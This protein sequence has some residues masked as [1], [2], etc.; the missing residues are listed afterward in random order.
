MELTKGDLAWR[1][2]M[3]KGCRG[4][5]KTK[6]NGAGQVV[7]GDARSRAGFTDVGPFSHARLITQKTS[8]PWL[9]SLLSHLKSLSNFKK[10]F[11]LLWDP[12]IM[13]PILAGNCI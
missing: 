10:L 4:I 6:S 11:S 12:Q 2:G 1:D 9:N 7:L 8:L 3:E 13:Q 5:E